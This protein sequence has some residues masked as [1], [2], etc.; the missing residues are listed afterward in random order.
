MRHER[1]VLAV[2]LGLLAGPGAASAAVPNVDIGVPSG[3]LTH[4]VVGNELSCQAQHTGDTRF[5]F[6]PSSTSPGDCG[7]FLAVGGQLF[8]PDFPN[9]DSTFAGFGSSFPKF[10]PT[11]QT[12]KTGAG[13]RTNP[14]KVVTN[15]NAGSTGLAIT[16]TDTYVSGEESYKTDIAVRNNGGGAQ[17]IRLYR[18]GDCFLQDD[19]QGFGFTGPN[20]AVGCSKN[21]NNS[22]AGRIE[23][24][25]PITGGASFLEANFTEVWDAVRTQNPFPNACARCT[26]KVDNGM[27]ISWGATINP[28]QTQTFTHFTT[29]SPTGVTGPP[30]SASPG[31]STGPTDLQASR[32]PNCFAVPSVTRNV[33]AN[34]RGV[35][36]VV[37]ATQQVDN[38]ANPLKLSLRF[39]GRG[40]IT[41]ASF[42]VNGIP[43]VAS[44]GARPSATVPI[45]PLRIGSRSRNR[46]TA[47]AIVNNAARARLTQ[48]MVILRC[49]VPA[50]TCQRLGNGTRLR[51]SSRT[52]GSGRRVSVTVTRSAA[53]TARGSA[54]VSRGR[55]TAFVSSRRPLGRGVYAYKAVVRTN[56]R[57]VKFQMIRRVTV[58]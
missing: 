51:C 32:I 29:F 41:A 49:A 9:H 12:A 2:T 25:V 36:S 24:F 57:G 44:L 7:T 20:G 28:G 43:T 35:G 45:G 48:F 34:I 6:F 33:V 17:T 47:N 54:T 5:E 10:T 52:P 31:G 38:P 42:T 50:V 1:L 30:P 14:F 56:I 40:G 53:E 23:E 4:V 18:A 8:A 37:L 55:Y 11:G 13:T 15:V 39:T 26:E 16:Q 3:P 58:T 19:D 27:G 21:P 22:P 46:I